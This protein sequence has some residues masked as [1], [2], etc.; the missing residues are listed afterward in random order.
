MTQATESEWHELP[1]V[2]LESLDPTQ[3]IFEDRA[4]EKYED[5]DELAGSIKEKGFIQPVAVCRTSDPNRYKLLAGG[6]RFSAAVLAKLRPIPA[7]IFPEDL[8]ELDRKEIELFENIH[9]RDLSW[10]E[11]KRLTREIHDIKVTQYGV[12]VVGGT[13]KE[14]RGHS[15]EDTADLIGKSQASVSRDIEMANALDSN[16]ELEDAK[17]EAEAR[18][19]LKKIDRKREDARAAAKFEEMQES[20][21]RVEE[22]KTVLAN[23]YVVGDFLEVSKHAAQNNINLIEIDPPYAI[24]LNQIKKAEDQIT[25]GYTEISEEDYPQFLRDV[26]SASNNLLLSSGWVVCWF[27]FQWYQ[28]IIDAF[29]ETGFTPCP[30]PGYWVKQIAGQT[31]QPETRLGSVIEGFIYARKGNAVLRKQ[32]RNNSFP[33]QPV[34]TDYKVHPTE[35]PIE[36]IEDLIET[37]CPPS[38]MVCSPFLGSG[39][40]LL[41]AANLGVHCWGCDLD[42]ENEYKNAYINRVQSGSPGRYKSYG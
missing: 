10:Q 16:P 8:S 1:T 34:P 30:I 18:R 12:A 35:R 23:A 36:M 21:D 40:T 14:K 20:E 25:E 24:K 3:I 42:I 41:A 19:M 26:F 13:G 15:K 6:R 29:K 37:F 33:Y 39:N 31:L 28:E 27:A 17:S 11:T 9:R 2:E 22:F 7:R 5:L 38:G 32:G 4:R